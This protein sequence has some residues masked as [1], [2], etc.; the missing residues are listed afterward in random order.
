MIRKAVSTDLEEIVCIIHEVKKLMIECGNPQWD[1]D[2]PGEKEYRR[3]ILRGELYVEEQEGA[4]AGFVTVNAVFPKEY[5]DLVWTTELPANTLHRLAVNPLFR[6]KGV[7]RLLFDYGEFVSRSQGMRSIRLDTF[8]LNHAAQR[9]F[10]N[11]GYHFAGQIQMKGRS[12]PYV[13]FEKTLS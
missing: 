10:I 9:M 5:E 11:N 1:S 3:D 8:S 12:V 2:Y 4:I 13:C 7:A 6:N